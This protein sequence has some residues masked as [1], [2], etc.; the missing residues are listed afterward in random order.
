M[1][2]L[3][4][5]V[6]M[7]FVC[8]CVCNNAFLILNTNRKTIYLTHECLINSNLHSFSVWFCLICLICVCGKNEI[9]VWCK[10]CVKQEG[11][12]TTISYSNSDPKF[13]RSRIKAIMLS[14][15][16]LGSRTLI[17]HS[18]QPFWPF[19]LVCVCVCISYYVVI[20]SY[21]CWMRSSDCV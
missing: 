8:V 4:I 2:V 20:G 9:L 6:S 17:R 19:M 15:C 12:P 10:Q 13:T 3:C 16:V 1:N 21:G 11:K 14:I 5:C 18:I 7:Q